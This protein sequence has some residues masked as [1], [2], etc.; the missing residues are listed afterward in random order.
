MKVEKVIVGKLECNCY[1]LSI[2]D[3]CIVIDPGADYLKIKDAI[4]NKSVKAVLITHNHFDHIGALSNFDKN[5]VYDFS[6]LE[7][8]E[9]QFSKFKFKVIKTPGHTSDLLT[10]YFFNDR[11]MF[12]GD[13][14]FNNSIGR[15]DFPNSS[16]YDMINSLNKI[17][18]Y[19]DDTII[20]PGHGDS[21]TLRIEKNNIP[22]Y[23]SYLN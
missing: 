19:P 16:S 14:L 8:K 10:Y 13:F 20:Y 4:N 17:S 15:T 23:I 12:T 18:Q 22:M 3:E 9:Y 11:V 21:S 2:K 6:N 7:E 5:I 1:I